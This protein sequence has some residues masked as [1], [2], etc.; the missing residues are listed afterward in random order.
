MRYR[1]AMTVS[2]VA[3]SSYFA[4]NGPKYGNCHL[5]T[6]K[7]Y[8]SWPY[9]TVWGGAEKVEVATIDKTYKL[10]VGSALFNFVWVMV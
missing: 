9:G 1:I 10:Q 3:I 4:G 7:L 2:E 5:R 6:S 8:S